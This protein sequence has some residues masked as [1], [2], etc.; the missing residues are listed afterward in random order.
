M[1]GQFDVSIGEICKGLRECDDILEVDER[2]NCL[3]TMRLTASNI[4][5]KIARPY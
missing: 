2:F 4:T 3:F 1:L 5:S